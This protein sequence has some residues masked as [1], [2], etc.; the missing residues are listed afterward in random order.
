MSFAPIVES[1]STADKRAVRAAVAAPLTD[2]EVSRL[3][4]FPSAVEGADAFFAQVMAVLMA[5]DRLDVEV[6]YCAPAPTRATRIYRLPHGAAAR[7]LAEE[8]HARD[9]PLIR[10]DAGTV[11][12]GRARHR[13][14]DDAKLHGE[15]YVDN[16]RLFNGEVRGVEIEPLPEPPGLR[17]RLE[18]PLIAPRWH[19]GR[20]AQTG[21]TNIVVEREGVLT[22]R[23]VKRSTFYRHHV[24]MKLVCP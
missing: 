1:E 11:L 19:L 10:D 22:P 17:A 15:T 18:R 8:G 13:G 2:P 16:D 4:V 12:V 24:D 9:L 23:V 3:I 14:A 5:M 6:A 7:R 20:A 21:G